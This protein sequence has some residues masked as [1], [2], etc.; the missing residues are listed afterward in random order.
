MRWAIDLIFLAILLL[1]GW[2]GYRKGLIMGIG[3][4]LGIIV[5]LYAACLISGT[6]SYEVVPVVRPFAAGYVER[7]ISTDVS[8]QLGFIY[9]EDTPVSDR[10]SIN[11]ALSQDPDAAGRFAVITYQ[12]LGIYKST[13]EKMAEEALDYGTV[14]Q[15]DIKSAII[16]VLCNRIVYVAGVIL[17]FFIILIVLVV[18]ANLPNL[19]FRLPNMAEADEIGGAV[20]GIIKGVLLCMLLA[21][22][23]KFAGLIIGKDTMSSTLLGRLFIKIGFIS[24]FIGI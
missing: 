1:C 20:T 8:E 24:F 11:D 22:A 10:Y 15:T 6:F 5:S 4:I 19:S 9:G 7:V 2:Y 21:W 12:G 16:E 13:A 17:C 3:G 18:L 23:L 14:H